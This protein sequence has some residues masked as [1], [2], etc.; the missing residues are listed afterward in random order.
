MKIAVAGGLGFIGKHIITALLESEHEVTL[1]A[2]RNENLMPGVSFV[3]A[4]L[5]VPGEWQKSL[6]GNDVVINLV[7]VNLFQRWNKDVKKMI[8]D[9]RIVSTANIIDSFKTPKSKGKT[10]INASAV[11]FYGLRGDEIVTEL[12][13]AG[14]DF[15]A[16]VCSN[17]EIEA[18]KGEKK[19]L[20][21]VLLRF[22]SVFGADD[23]AFPVL[24]K[25]FKLM[26]GAKLG[27][28]R[29]WFPWI[30]VD[31]VSGI[32]LKAVSDKKM[33]GPYNCTSPG[34]VTNG[35]FTLTMARAVK[36][37]VLIP[38]VPGFVLRILFG[39]FGSFLTGG[40]RAVPE[41][42]LKEGYKFRFPEL[43]GALED[44]LRQRYR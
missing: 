44:L 30:H 25:N 23:G 33:N 41:K 12:A 38:F 32:I 26:L 34:I 42:L 16:K 28:G 10:L 7:G 6:S 40:Q 43:S 22:G 11:G 36:R 1:Y 13:D 37:P 20:R 3:Y 29:Q 35:D 14:P 17:W 8:Y 2:R 31:D 19:K 21:V 18:S 24:A 4:D 15:L 27:N 39:E 5:M 9:S